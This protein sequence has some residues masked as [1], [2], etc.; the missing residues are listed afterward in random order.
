MCIRDSDYLDRLA[1]YRAFS[2]GTQTDSANYIYDA[3]DRI[4]SEQE[5]HPNQAQRTTTYS[6]QGVGSQLTEEQQSNA[7]GP[8]TVKDYTYDAFGH[9]LTMTNTPSGQAATTYSYGYNVHD[10]VSLL[11]DPN[12][13]AKASYGYSAYGDQ[14]TSL[15]QGDTDKTNPFNAFRYTGKRYDSGSGSMNMGARSFNPGTDSFLQPDILHGAQDNL[16]LSGDQSSQNRYGLAGGNPLSSIESDGHMALMDGGGGGTSSPIPTN[17]SQSSTSGGGGKKNCAPWDLGCQGSQFV[18]GLGDGLGDMWKGAKAL[19]SVAMDCAQGGAVECGSRL[20]KMGSYVVDHPGDFF[21]SLIDYKDLSQGNYAKWAGHLAPSI[22]LTI[23]TVGG[24]GALAKAG[25]AAGLAAEGAEVAGEAGGVAAGEAAG[26]AG[27]AAAEAGSGKAVEASGEAAGDAAAGTE[28]AAA[29][30]G[31]GAAQ[32][33][34]GRTAEGG[35]GSVYHYTDETGRAGIESS[36]TI[37]PG[38]SGKTW[39]SPTRYT[40]QLQAQQEL[41]LPRTP[42]SVM[43]IPKGRIPNLTD[44]TTVERRFGQPGGGLESFTTDNVNVQG[45]FFEDLPQ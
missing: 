2:G 29:E 25:E 36:G 42:T 28:K 31:S 11:L 5:T 39:F 12:G 24:A 38:A 8:I 45:L 9:R 35:G 16:G 30:S 23:A 37:R 27:V 14:D 7:S 43:E 33:S 4:V 20:E 40:N 32:A 44:A 26:E 13:N 34:A 17:T 21:G 18:Q 41:A 15:S 6:Y 10:S 22:V 3:L 1:G 19:G